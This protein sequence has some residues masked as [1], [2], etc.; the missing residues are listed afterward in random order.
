MLILAAALGLC[1]APASAQLSTQEGSHLRL[2]YFDG[3]ESYLVPYAVRTFF[4]SLAFQLKILGYEPAEDITVLLADFEDY[5]NA[6]VSVVPRST[7]MVQIA[8]LSFAFETIAAN[9]RM[10]TIMNHELVHVATMDQATKRDR[11]FRRLFGGKVN[12]IAAQPETILYMYLTA[13]RVAAPRW[14]H[15]GIAVFIDTWMAGGIGRAQSGYDEMVFRSMVR[16]GAHFYDPLG[17]VSEGTKIDFQL[18]INSYLYGTRFMMW[19]ANTYGPEKLLDWVKRQEG[20]RGYYATHFKQVF[21]RSL[22]DGWREWIEWERGFQQKNLE[23]IRTYP[24]TPYTDVSQRALGSV[25]R[26]YYDEEIGKIYAAFNYPGVVAHVG[27]ID[28]KS[29]ALERLVD[30]KGPVVYTVTSLA[31]DP[32]EKVLFYTTDNGAHRDLVRLDPRT[33]NTTLLMKDLRVGDLAFNRADRSLWGIRHLN[34]ICTLVRIPPPYTE[35][36]RVHSWPYGTVVYDLDVSP[37]GTRVS[38]SFGEVTGQQDVRVFETQPLLAGTV[39]PIARFDFGQSVPSGFVF[40]ADGRTLV[41]S[42]YF[43]GVSNIFSYD[44]ETKQ[45]AALSNTETGFFRPVPRPEDSDL[46]VFRYSGEGFVASR[47]KPIPLKDI[48]PITFFGERLVAGH[49]VL[50]SWLLGSPADVNVEEKKLVEGKYRLAGGLQRESI[51]PILQGYKDSAAVGVRANFSDA[52][53]LNRLNLSASVSPG[54]GLPSDERVHLRAD[55]Q[56]YDWRARATYN[57]ADFYDLFGPTKTSR[58]GYSLGLG[59]HRTLLYD[60]P[61]RIELETDAMFAGNLDR[62]P[63]YQNVE[64]QID[65]L[66]AFEAVLKG[67]HI[68][69]SLGRVDDEKG[70]KWSTGL[71][72]S[73]VAG[74]WNTRWQG[75]FDAGVPLP[76]AHSSLWVRSAAGF[77]PGDRDDPF[78][79][80]FFGGF[81]NNYVDY[82]DEKRYRMPWAFPGLDLNELGGRTY[83]RSMVELNL[84]P[85]R[86]QRVGTAG[87][88]A[89]WMRPALFAS[90]LTTE[91]GSDAFRRV[92]TNAGAQVDFQLSALSALDMVLSFGGAVAFEDG[93]RPRREVMASF[94]ILR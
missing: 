37:D 68:R 47:I 28:V 21:G 6:G 2:V 40:S 83:L 8:P 13:P 57:D 69:S 74:A 33:G 5:G 7:M 62:L 90:V 58:K 93:F 53:Q 52:L 70:T 94:K 89:T 48:S 1:P 32:G 75:T 79:N 38:A 55:Y 9:E 45:T 46:F 72:G 49:P 91:P 64:V 26:A 71:D 60:E 86:F 17:L 14:Y 23:A 22:P 3:A 39:E 63:Q 54:S 73:V 25:S 36:T 84:P 88:Y 18:Q 27:S 15:E 82:R 59:Y 92:V 43:T 35:W 51:Y 65:R 34:G 20:S 11:M 29:G 16:D 30:I 81:G 42:S 12:P 41:G 80:F 67:R 4:N 66:F 24:T 31:Y 44:F 56:R 87:F 19:L 50:K 77:S 10:N 61:R 85:W 76:V 78:A